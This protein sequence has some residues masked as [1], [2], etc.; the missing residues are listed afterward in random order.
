MARIEFDKSS[1]ESLARLLV[2]RLRDDFDLDIA[3]MD[4]Q[5]LLDLL[6]EVMGP[7]FYNQG[8][9]DAEAALRDR[10]EAIA[11]AIEGLTRP[12]PR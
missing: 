6:S 12:T 4:G 9:F 1:R 2:K 10:V 7:H 8:L 11:E 5:R 3:P